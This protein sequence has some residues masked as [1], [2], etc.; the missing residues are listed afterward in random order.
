MKNLSRVTG[1]EAYGNDI[2]GEAH[3][4]R[5][6]IARTDCTRLIL[7][8]ICTDSGKPFAVAMLRAC[9]NNVATTDCFSSN[10]PG[11]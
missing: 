7:T 10:E 3:I 2:P 4:K 5:P 11:I 1:R 9:S 8:E 6:A